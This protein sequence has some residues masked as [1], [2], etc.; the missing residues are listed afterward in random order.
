MKI[1]GPDLA[2]LEKIAR[3]ALEELSQVQGIADPGAFWVLGQ[4]NLNIRVDRIRAARYGLNVNDVNS[5]VQAA[6]GGTTATTMLEAD[7][8]FGVVVR[9]ASAYRNNIDDVRNIK[10]GYQTPGGGMPTSH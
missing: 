4:P 8:Q 10:V 6:L 7:R 1:I 2:V 5:V 9:L 3:A